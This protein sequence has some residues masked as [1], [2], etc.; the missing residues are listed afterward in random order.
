MRLAWV[1]LIVEAALEGSRDKFVQALVIEG[2]V[3]SLDTARKLADE[4][5]TAQAQYLPQFNL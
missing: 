4:L 1:E 2:A 3:D 5:L